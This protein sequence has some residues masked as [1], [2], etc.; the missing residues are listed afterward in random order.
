MYPVAIEEKNART[1]MTMIESK[2]D[3]SIAWEKRGESDE[4]E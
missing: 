1:E 4:N 2:Y 3:H